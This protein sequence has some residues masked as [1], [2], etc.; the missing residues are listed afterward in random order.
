M[1]DEDIIDVVFLTNVAFKMNEYSYPGTNL[2]ER[3]TNFNYRLSRARRVIENAFGILTARWRILKTTLGM[4][5]RNVDKI[6]N[7]TIVLHNFVKLNDVQYC[8]SNMTDHTVNGTEVLGLWRQEVQPLT[9]ANM[10]VSNF[11]SRSALQMR[12]TL[13]EYVFLNKL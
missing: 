3:K 11:S 13:C 12:D 9:Q 4:L 5:P 10:H 1:D 8:P 6:V 7:A 2:G